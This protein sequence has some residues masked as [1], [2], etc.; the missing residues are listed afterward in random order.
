[1]SGCLVTASHKQ[2]GYLMKSKASIKAGTASV[3]AATTAKATRRLRPK[4]VGR[5]SGFAARL[6]VCG[7][8]AGNSTNLPSGTAGRKRLRCRWRGAGGSS[9]ARSLGVSSACSFRS[10]F[11]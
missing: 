5:R 10:R 8:C 3:V 6:G 9:D 4:A 1:M 2:S 11:R 7:C